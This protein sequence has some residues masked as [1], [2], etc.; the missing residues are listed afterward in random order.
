MT[1]T[2]LLLASK[3]QDITLEIIDADACLLFC[4][5]GR[6]ETGPVPAPL[7]CVKFDLSPSKPNQLSEQEPELYGAGKGQRCPK[8]PLGKEF[9]VRQQS[10]RVA[11]RE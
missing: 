11:A 8:M 1:R 6:L 9:R 4:A 10:D 7:S 5:R 3:S 2:K